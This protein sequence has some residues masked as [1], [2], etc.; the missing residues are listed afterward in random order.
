MKDTELMTSQE[1]K[2]YI[3]STRQDERK[4]NADRKINDTYLK[5]SERRTDA[6]NRR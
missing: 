1:F 4:K 3:H 2:A 6:N 5:H